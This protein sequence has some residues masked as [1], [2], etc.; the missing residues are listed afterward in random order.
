MIGPEL[1]QNP[2]LAGAIMKNAFVFELSRALTF[3]RKLLIVPPDTV[4]GDGSVPH[5]LE[6]ADQRD[7][8]VFAAHVRVLPDLL[9][10]IRA[11]S[12]QNRFGPDPI[13]NP[14][15]VSLAFKHLHKTWQESQYGLEQINSYMGGVVWR[16][17]SENLYAVNHRLPTPYVINPTPEDITYF[18]HQIHFG[19]L[20]HSWPHACL[21]ETERQRVVG[22]S[23]A[24]FMV[25]LTDAEANIPPVAHYRA[26]EP[27][28]FW[29]NLSHNKVNRMNTIIFRG[30]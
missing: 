22:S 21:I 17:L 28:L 10:N 3:N 13:T 14:K 23:D 7:V 27:D 16:Y 8:V 15:L 29:R 30:E 6:V 5:L 4:W 20:D 12:D 11:G 19:V 18:Q 2:N 25:E 9:E 24:A 1:D 26:D